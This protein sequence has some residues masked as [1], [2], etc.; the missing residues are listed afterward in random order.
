V[1]TQPWNRVIVQSDGAVSPCCYGA[2]SVGNIAT[3]EFEEVVNGEK[4]LALKK[5]LLTGEGLSPQCRN[6]VGEPVGTTDQLKASLHD[7]FKARCQH[8]RKAS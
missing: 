8:A 5:S 4:M 2:D 6:C 1:C 3:R 7:Y